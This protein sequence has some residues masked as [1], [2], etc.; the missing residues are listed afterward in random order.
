MTT[1]KYKAKN[2]QDFI[3]PGIGASKNGVIEVT[4]PL[5][6]PSLEL[7]VETEPVEA[8]Q[9]AQPGAVIGVAPQATVT[10]Q[11]INVEELK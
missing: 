8:S 5:E 2:G 7:I 1:Y 3:L 10:Q 4:R 9:I 6:A 11:I